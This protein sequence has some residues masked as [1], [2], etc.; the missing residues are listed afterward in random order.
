MNKKDCPHKRIRNIENV[1]KEKVKSSSWKKS[2]C[3]DCKTT[4]RGLNGK[5]K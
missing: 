2:V 5:D 1:G 4:F 3:I